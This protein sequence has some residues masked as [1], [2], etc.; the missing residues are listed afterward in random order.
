MSE[1]IANR[2][3]SLWNDLRP[4]DEFYAR[5]PLLAHYT[6]MEVLEKILRTNEIWFS[7]PL[8]MNDI[9]EVRFGL[10]ESQRLVMA[11]EGISRVCGD[12]TRIDLFRNA[13]L[14]NYSQFAVT[15]VIDTYVLCLSEH[16]KTND[17]GVLSMWRGYG[18]NGHGAAIVLD[19]SKLNNL[20]ASTFML[21]KVQYGSGQDRTRWIESKINEFV[22]L[23]SSAPI[24]TG[25]LP[26]AAFW[27]FQRFKLFSLSQNITGF[28]KRPSGAWFI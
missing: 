6:S 7:N 19:A 15:Q 5:K 10:N 16:A 28:Q 1:P 9:E 4:E 21:A 3:F 13:F 24:A 11:S 27:L 17:D 25:E 8:L 22:A 20:P 18:G 12:Q 14:K 2:L 26:E 23:F